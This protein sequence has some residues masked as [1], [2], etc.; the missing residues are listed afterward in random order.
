M[1]YLVFT[2]KGSSRDLRKIITAI[3]KS[4]FADG[5]KKINY[6]HDYLL[7]DGKVEKWEEKI[8]LVHSENQDGLLDFL[9]KKFPQLEKMEI[10]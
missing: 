9:S 4:W 7:K 3:L 8:I 2:Y 10:R 5:I 1:C 6:V